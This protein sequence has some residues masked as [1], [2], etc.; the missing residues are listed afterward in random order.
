MEGSPRKFGGFEGGG[1]G[2]PRK[3]GLL[4]VEGGGW[5]GVMGGFGELVSSPSHSLSTSVRA[6]AGIDRSG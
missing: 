5:G 4:E 1:G 3:L 2:T 6:S